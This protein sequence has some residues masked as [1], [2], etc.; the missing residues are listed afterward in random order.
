MTPPDTKAL[1]ASLKALLLQNRIDPSFD[2]Q[3]LAE[4]EIINRFAGIL[5]ELEGQKEQY[6]HYYTVYTKSRERIAELE[7]QLT[8]AQKK[9]EE[10]SH[11]LSDIEH[12]NRRYTEVGKDKISLVKIMPAVTRIRA[13]IG[14]V[15]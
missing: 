2:M 8:I 3:I 5:S 15:E 1:K 11:H 7:S 13:A 10:V 12:S 9:I 4:E 6:R 14:G